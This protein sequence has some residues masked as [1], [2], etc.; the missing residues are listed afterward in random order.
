MVASVDRYAGESRPDRI[1]PGHGPEGKVYD[2]SNTGR[3]LL[4]RSSIPIRPQVIAPVEVVPAVSTKA[5]VERSPRLEGS[6]LL[7]ASTAISL[8]NLARDGSRVRVKQI[9]I[10]ARVP[11]CGDPKRPMAWMGPY[12][13][14]R[15]PTQDLLR[16]REP[17]DLTDPE[18]RHLRSPSREGVMVGSQSKPF[19]PR[20]PY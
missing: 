6:N 9:L 10:H 12:E 18:P 19:L 13:R 14:R 5:D 17:T 15:F 20:D 4:S 16:H 7:A 8:L 2:R 3:N 1:I 11:E